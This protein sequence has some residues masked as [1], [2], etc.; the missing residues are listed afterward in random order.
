MASSEIPG[1][2]LFVTGKEVV[3]NL[4][5]GQH[6]IPMDDMLKEHGKNIQLTPSRIDISKDYYSNGTG[7]LFTLP[8]N[9]GLEG[10]EYSIYRSVFRLRWDWYKELGYPEVNNLDDMINVMSQMQKAHPKAADGKSVYGISNYSD[11]L[12]WL[13][14][15]AYTNTFGLSDAGN[16]IFNMHDSSD[17]YPKYDPNSK[18]WD[19]MKYYNK[20]NRAGIF[21]PDSFTQSYDD[22]VAK[23]N[24]GQVMS[25]TTS[26]FVLPFNQAEYAKDNTSIAGIQA[27]PVDGTSVHTNVDL[28]FGFNG[29]L[30]CIN[31][32]SKNP[33]KA[34]DVLDYL[35][36]Y[37]GSR[38]AKSGVKGVNWDI[39]DGVAQYTDETAALVKKGGDEYQKTGISFFEHY[40][41]FGHGQA[42]PDDG[43]P[44]YLIQGKVALKSQNLPVD[45]DFNSKYN[46]DYPYQAFE[47]KIKEGKMKDYSDYPLEYQMTL[48]IVPD[49]INLIDTKLSDLAT[50]A[51]P[52]LVLA[53]D[54]AEFEEVKAALINDLDKS[55]YAKSLEWWM[56]AISK[57]LATIE[58]YK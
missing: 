43:E 35:F 38:L 42:D 13:G 48:E 41:G 25:P 54:D 37:E 27:I 14:F 51:L 31:K 9:V 15:G 16:V 26:W 7:N 36:S 10:H 44:M 56:P 22:F 53:K 5:K 8:S 49:D 12:M 19:A 24:N 33:E 4:I 3:Q 2:I 47:N 55:G 39:I 28:K 34:M 46:C 50:K 57:A 6:I 18:F 1:D 40:A 52:K 17:I 30:M 45:N 29:M 11:G 32:G 58:T 21:D 20:A 23:V